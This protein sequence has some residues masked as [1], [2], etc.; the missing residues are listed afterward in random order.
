MFNTITEAKSIALYLREGNREHQKYRLKDYISFRQINLVSGRECIKC[1]F[2]LMDE[3][4]EMY[5]NGAYLCGIGGFTIMT[6]GSCKRFK[7]K[8][9]VHA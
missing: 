5:S 2:Q 1:K 9:V 8:V 6:N 4:E 7:K 3:K